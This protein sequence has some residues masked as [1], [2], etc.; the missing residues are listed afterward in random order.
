VTGP[1]PDSNPVKYYFSPVGIRSFTITATEFNRQTSSH[2]VD[3]PTAH[4]VNLNLHANRSKY[5][6]STNKIAFPLVQ[7]MGFVSARYYNLVPV[8][9]SGIMFR[10]IAP[11]PAP[12]AGMQKWIVVLEDGKIWIVYAVPALET[13]SLAL[14]RSGNDKLV[15]SSA[16]TGTIQISKLSDSRLESILDSAAG[17]FSTGVSLSGTIFG[18]TGSYTFTY[19]KVGQNNALKLLMYALPHHMASFNSATLSGQTN[20]ALH[21]P[22]KG[23]MRGVL[24]DAW[25]M[26]ETGLV[27]TI[28]WLPA[29]GMSQSIANA[30]TESASRDLQQDMDQQSNLDSMYFSGTSRPL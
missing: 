22:T 4:S 6:D 2:T 10:S 1:N 20:L 8:L 11:M 19:T 15:G 5:G 21:S 25:S 17:A 16:F 27:T 28:N 24:A 9:A 30:V 26:Y 3:S 12:R 14:T 18:S 13:A 7:G 23:L 29:G